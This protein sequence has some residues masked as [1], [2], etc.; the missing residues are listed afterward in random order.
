MGAVKFLVGSGLLGIAF[1]LGICFREQGASLLRVVGPAE[2][3]EMF[4]EFQDGCAGCP[5]L[6]IVPAGDGGALLAVGKHEITFEEW[7]ACVAAGG[8]D[9]EPD[10]GGWNE[11]ALRP[12][13]N[14]T[15]PDVQAYLNWLSQTTHRSYR[16]LTE[17]E[18]ERASR[19]QS[20]RDLYWNGGAKVACQFA[21]VHG[22]ET[23]GPQFFGEPHDCDDGFAGPSPVT[24]FSA[25]PFGLHD[26]IGNV[27]EWVADQVLKGG[28]WR[29]SEQHA[30]AR[31]RIPT[32]D[33]SD[34]SDI[35]I[36]FRI[37]TTDINHSAD[38]NDPFAVAANELW[39]QLLKQKQGAENLSIAIKP[40][41]LI[42]P[43]PLSLETANG[44]NADLRQALINTGTNWIQ[45]VLEGYADIVISGAIE[46][47]GDY[48]VL[49][50]QGLMISNETLVASTKLRLPVPTIFHP[51]QPLDDAVRAAAAYMA[52]RVGPIATVKRGGVVV[53]GG[54]LGAGAKDLVETK[55][56]GA[57][58]VQAPNGIN[59]LGPTKIMPAWADW[60]TLT[61]EIW[62]VGE[63]EISMR[64]RL[65]SA[66]DQSVVIWEGYI[67]RDSL[68][69]DFF[70]E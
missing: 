56:I 35:D 13:I 30:N 2:A 16:L 46:S 26:T 68:P 45:I 60:F 29:S 28:S 9:Y 39:G 7:D 17:A 58:S 48:F 27:W 33:K 18:W 65:E 5:V 47:E 40:F 32:A 50:Y 31:S 53:H 22:V 69:A 41:D 34:L 20:G 57:I 43:L 6:V 61:G 24:A 67:R 38:S 51:V 23:P 42:T 8:C 54:S 49:R 10:D 59:I 64:F 36:G 55:I 21:N 25:N 1:F 62:F 12:V 66:Y 52:G 15:W 11:R 14:V 63:G 3:S 4:A 44:Y 19:A 37:A 70:G